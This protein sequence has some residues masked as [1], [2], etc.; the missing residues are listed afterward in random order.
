MKAIIE[1]L[2][3]LRGNEGISLDELIA[4]IDEKEDDIRKSIREL[5][6][7]CQKE[8]RGIQVEMLGNKLK[9]TT[10]PEHKSFYQKLT[11]NEVNTPLSKSALET[12]A[13][14]AY[15]EPITKVEIDDIRGINSSYVVR[16]LLLKGLIQEKGRSSLPGKPKQYG[17][18]D[19]FLDHFGL[20]ST[21]ELPVINFDKIINKGQTEENLFLSKYTELQ[22]EKNE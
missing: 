14:I 4:I 13:I 9:F 12:L 8:D 10:K 18:T 2:L 20:N 1:G 19:L 5:Y 7:D 6:D 21:K 17:V 16:K 15:N 11:N 3:F 22:S